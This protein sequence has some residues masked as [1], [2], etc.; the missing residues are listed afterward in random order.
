[1]KISKSSN[2]ERKGCKVNDYLLNHL[3]S[4]LYPLGSKNLI[5]DVGVTC[6]K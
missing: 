5:L 2:F 4:S 1:M 3:A 6:R